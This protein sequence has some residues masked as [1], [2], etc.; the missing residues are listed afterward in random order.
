MASI[1]IWSASVSRL[2]FRVAERRRIHHAFCILRVSRERNWCLFFRSN[3]W[4]ILRSHR[5]G[6]FGFMQRMACM[7]RCRQ[8]ATKMGFST[9]SRVCVCGT[10]RSGKFYLNKN[11]RDLERSI[12]MRVAKNTLNYGCYVSSR[13]RIFIYTFLWQCAPRPSVFTSKN[14]NPNNQQRI[15]RMS[16]RHLCM[17]SHPVCSLCRWQK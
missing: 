7:R 8:V 9:N 16:C 14:S 3:K 13:Q 6:D 12:C 15:E 2:T 11:A 5:N 4:Q 17:Y 10:F 1:W